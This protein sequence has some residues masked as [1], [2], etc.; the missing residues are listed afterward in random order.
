MATVART[1]PLLGRDRELA[2][3]DAGLDEARQGRGGAAMLDGEAGIGKTRLAAELRSRAAEA[4]FLVAGA[5]CYE[6]D[7]SPP[8]G[9]WS[10]AIRELGREA[11][12]A[13]PPA[14]VRVL[15]EVMPEL[16]DAPRLE[17]PPPLSPEEA[18]FRATDAVV[19]LLLDVAAGQP[20]L[21][22]VDDLQWADPASLDVLGYLGRFL[23]RTQLLVVGAYRTRDVGLEHPLARALAELDRHAACSR[24]A[25]GPLDNAD[26]LA[27]VERLA[28]KLPPQ[29]AAEIVREANGHPFFITEVVR[30][31]LDQGRDPPSAIEVRVPQSVRHAVAARLARLAPRTRRV[32]EVA[33][34][35]TRPFEL[36]VLAAM[37]DVDEEELLSA[38]DEAL[39]AQVLHATGEQRYE[40][41]HALV[42]RTLY[43]EIGPSRRARLHRRIAQALERV[44]EGRELE[45][46]GELAAQYH[47]SAS[48]PGGAHGIRYALA[49]AEQA[50]AAH[51]DEQAVASLRRARDLAVAAGAP[52]RSEVTCR[53][54]VAEAE[55]LLLE[56]AARSAE[57]ALALLE[58]SGADAERLAAFVVAV[59]RPLQD[60]SMLAWQ[61]MA[62]GAREPVL[63][64]L[65]ER[66]LS[67]RGEQRDL[68]W[69]RLKLLE[70]PK[71]RDDSGPVNSGRWLGFDPEALAIA[72]A[73]GDEDDYAATL[74]SSDARSPAETRALLERVERW[75]TPTAKIRGFGGVV[76]T[77]LVQHGALREAV[78][79]ASRA[80]AYSEEVGSLQGQ[81]DAVSARAFARERLGEFE[82][83]VADARRADELLAHLTFGDPTAKLPALSME[84]RVRRWQEVDWAAFARFYRDSALESRGSP[85]LVGLFEAALAAEAFARAGE[86]AEARGLLDW[87]LPSILASEPTRLQHNG[88]VAFA[89]GA[90]WELA[91]PEHAV[92]LRRAAV[93]VIEAGVGD[94]WWTSNELT[95]A[96]MSSLLGGVAEAE[97]WFERARGALEASGQRPLR[98]V[99]DYDE[100][101]HRR[102]HGLP[103]APALLA[104]ARRRFDELQMHEWVARA[105]RLA[106]DAGGRF[107]DGLTARE[108]EVLRLVAGGLTNAEIAAGLVISVHTVE[109]H[110]ANVYRKIGVRNRAEAATYTLQAG[111]CADT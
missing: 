77:M 58:E 10:L 39:D 88:A 21:I 89:G 2:V 66:G 17:R 14:R 22:V 31:L 68:T 28:H 74:V 93:A 37:T 33:A 6:S 54:A 9:L 16:E 75:A 55:A 63:T 44:Y 19:R 87:I 73:S 84:A 38:L 4:G 62:G 3:L 85:S 70:R 103:A 13:Q 101:R 32:L 7:W 90:V 36:F 43:D 95:V 92:A 108:V 76:Q 12:Q 61:L 27:L 57:E 105:D 53:L 91:E 29:L 11:L 102:R 41:S 49:A 50:R 46:A 83:A 99:I 100:A 18:R 110:L 111:L 94:C 79:V 80:L 56:D 48:L 86:A 26:A 72:R 64:R 34:A 8:F 98:A 45:Q 24:V 47:A 52:L 40:F 20:L 35:F 106:G 30:D 109:R 69:A 15:S 1:P 71:A 59:A 67:A 25:L 82:A 23:T 60:A 51:A 42:R 104:E 97:E 78:D 81:L 5:T 107:P 65:V 96:R